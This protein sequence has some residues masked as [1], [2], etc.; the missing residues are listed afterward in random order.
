MVRTNK[1]TRDAPTPT[2]TRRSNR[3]RNG[4]VSGTPGE[5]FRNL[6]SAC[7]DDYVPVADVV[8]D[9]APV[10]D[11]VVVSPPPNKQSKKPTA[12]PFF[13]TVHPALLVA[14]V[15]VGESL[16]AGH[17]DAIPDGDR[18]LP[19]RRDVTSK[20]LS[21]IPENTRDDDDL[22]LFMSSSGD[23]SESEYENF[24]ADFVLDPTSG[25]FQHARYSSKY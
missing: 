2:P 3:N 1:T 25:K 21:V 24:R 10:D 16:L 9:S 7:A 14:Q 22:Q 23:V 12:A 6:V 11:D 8:T 5:R 19:A 20:L 15:N 4:P 13:A 17:D 18:K